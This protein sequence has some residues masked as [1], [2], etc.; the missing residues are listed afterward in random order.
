VLLKIVYVL[1]CRVLGLAIPAF[2]GDR[3]EDAELARLLSRRCWTGIF[4]VTPA[5]FLAWHRKL[6]GLCCAETL[7]MDLTCWF[8][9][10][11]RAH[12]T[13]LPDPCGTR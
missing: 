7:H 4:P 10:G 8:T 13:R 6:A 2:R 3:A 9:L 12:P 1:T 11:A 5:T